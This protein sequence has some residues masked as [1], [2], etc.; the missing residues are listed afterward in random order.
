M[1]HEGPCAPPKGWFQLLGDH[2]FR[3]Y[4]S[5]LLNDVRLKPVDWSDN[6]SYTAV[7]FT[8]VGNGDVTGAIDRRENIG[9]ANVEPSFDHECYCPVIPPATKNNELDGTR[10]R[11]ALNDVVYSD[12]P[13]ITMEVMKLLP[14]ECKDSIHVCHDAPGKGQTCMR[15]YKL[16]KLDSHKEPICKAFT[17][18]RSVI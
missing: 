10:F 13:H 1:C 4:L 5:E 16:T 8:L 15:A 7:W 12:Y 2:T 6:E 11:D 18:L 3:M 17:Q 14:V 9:N